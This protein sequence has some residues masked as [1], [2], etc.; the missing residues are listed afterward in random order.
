MTAEILPLPIRSRNVVE[1]NAFRSP[2]N[3]AQAKA[4]VMAAMGHAHDDRLT[5]LLLAEALGLISAEQRE[6][7][8]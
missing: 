6:R 4:R 2:D 8:E 3:L 1:L 5:R 7:G